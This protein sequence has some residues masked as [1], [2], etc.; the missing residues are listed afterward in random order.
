MC[1]QFQQPMAN[2]RR[3]TYKGTVTRNQDKRQARKIR[4]DNE[5]VYFNTMVRMLSKESTTTVTRNATDMI[6]LYPQLQ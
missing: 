6:G 4:K 3:K 2:Y 5:W 1:A